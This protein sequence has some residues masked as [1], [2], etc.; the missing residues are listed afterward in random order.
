MHNWCPKAK[1][2]QREELQALYALA[3]NWEECFSH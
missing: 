3:E 2:L 1:R